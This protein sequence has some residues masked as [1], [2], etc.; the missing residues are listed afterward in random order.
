MAIGEDVCLDYDTFS[1]HSLDWELAAIN[2]GVN[3]FDDYPLASITL[4]EQRFAQSRTLHYRMHRKVLS[5][6]PCHVRNVSLLHQ[7]GVPGAHALE[8]EEIH[9]SRPGL[10]FDAHRRSGLAVMPLVKFTSLIQRGKVSQRTRGGG[11]STSLH[12]RGYVK[13]TDE[14]PRSPIVIV[15]W[16][17][18]R[19][20]VVA[21]VRVPR[22]HHWSQAPEGPGV[23]RMTLNK[24]ENDV[25]PPL[26]GDPAQ[27]RQ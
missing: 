1:C 11:V 16:Q 9:S 23:E 21:P 18:E 27:D 13:S 17:I 25:A 2:F 12:Q 8:S 22:T 15:V 6:R 26:I 24:I 20:V 19:P 10:I 7:F 14:R 4:L 5:E 3:P